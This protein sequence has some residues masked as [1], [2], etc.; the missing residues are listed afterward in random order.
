MYSV[1]GNGA[2]VPK[3]NSSSEKTEYQHSWKRAPR[4]FGMNVRVPQNPIGIR[5]QNLIKKTLVDIAMAPVQPVIDYFKNNENV[6]NGNVAAEIKSLEKQ[7][8]ITVDLLKD[9]DEIVMV[10]VPSFMM[11]M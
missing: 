7:Q 10:D 4:P 11:D 6:F 1:S 3:V 2:N 9:A 8:Q 5:T